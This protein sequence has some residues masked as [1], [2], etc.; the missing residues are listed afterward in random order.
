MV[1]PKPWGAQPGVE[2]IDNNHK[3]S[4]LL[5]RLSRNPLQSADCLPPQPLRLVNGSQEHWHTNEVRRSPTSRM[6]DNPSSPDIKKHK[7][8]EK[9]WDSPK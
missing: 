5:Q 3:I 6:Q 7:D 9:E 8:L 4:P 2:A 1:P